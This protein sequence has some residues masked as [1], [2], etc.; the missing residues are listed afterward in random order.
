MTEDLYSE[1]AERYDLFN[2]SFGRFSPKVR[3]F[4]KK[5]FDDH[6]VK[7][8]L[9]CACG[10]GQDLV[11]FKSLGVEIIGS[12]ISTAMLKRAKKNLASVDVEI[13]LHI[14]DFRKLPDYFERK[15]DAV[16]CLSSSIW[17]MP[18]N[19]QVIK[20][21]RS[22]RE[23]LNDNGIL[24][25]TQGTSDKQWEEKP[26]FI[27]AVN[28]EDFSRLFI[29]DYLDKGA[30][31]NILDFYHG[32]KEKPMETW[33]LYYPNILLRDDHEKLLKES[34]FKNIEFFGSYKPEPY[35]KSTSDRLIVVACK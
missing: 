20:A 9:D 12:D 19:T 31:F 2:E 14:L 30:R 32:D 15:F 27:L 22:M 18:D 1:F 34:G 7:S 21:Y 23:V 25:I 17:H 35:N 16:V 4:Y 33:S 5:L 29:I 8:V 26:R 3:L 28:R 24:V 13:D 11:L 10:T 6:N